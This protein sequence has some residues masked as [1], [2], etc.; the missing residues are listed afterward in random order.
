[1]NSLE[2]KY[3]MLFGAYLGMTLMDEYPLKEYILKDIKD[4]IID[5]TSEYKLDNYDYDTFMMK[6]DKEE[7][8]IVKLQDLYRIG[9]I[10]NFDIELR[11]LIKEKIRN[12]KSDN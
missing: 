9:N 10:L 4:Y 5:F 11:Y 3:K 1:M 8:E 2:D 12:Y 6:V 7:S